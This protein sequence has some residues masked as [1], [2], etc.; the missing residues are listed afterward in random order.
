MSHFSEHRLYVKQS[1]L[2]VSPVTFIFC[3][4]SQFL[5]N[6]GDF[7]LNF[8]AWCII[9]YVCDFIYCNNSLEEGG[10]RIVQQKKNLT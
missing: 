2:L 6:T 3:G 1:H 7:A 8:L 5:Q 9:N 10:G 4:L